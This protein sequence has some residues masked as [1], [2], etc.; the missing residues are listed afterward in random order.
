VKFKSVNVQHVTLKEFI[1]LKSKYLHP[2]DKRY[3]RI[4]H[5]LAVLSDL[6]HQGLG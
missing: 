4:Y 2:L 1:H 6:H 5:M 3:L